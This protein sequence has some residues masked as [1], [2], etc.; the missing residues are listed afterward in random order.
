MIISIDETKRIR[1]NGQE[2][3]TWV[4][5][6][7]KNSYIYDRFN[8][9]TLPQKNELLKEY[10]LPKIKSEKAKSEDQRKAS[11]EI[12]YEEVNNY[13]QRNHLK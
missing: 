3:Y 5:L 13:Y 1:R 8:K 2:Q 11:I 12:F 9:L 7:S 6:P 10:I 4:E